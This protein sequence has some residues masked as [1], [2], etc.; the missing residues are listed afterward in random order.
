MDEK[1]RDPR[2][3]SDQKLW[4]EVQDLNFEAVARDMSRGVMAIT[5]EKPSEVSTEDKNKE[6]K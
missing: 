6:N 2:L 1:R 4:C 3:E 5:V